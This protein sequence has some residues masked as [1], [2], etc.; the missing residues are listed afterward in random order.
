MIICEVPN[1]PVS[2]ISVMLCIRRFSQALES[3][4]CPKAVRQKEEHT[5]R[6]RARTVSDTQSG[7]KGDVTNFCHID[8]F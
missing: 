3:S 7:F 6:K 5:K 2:L 8:L 1:L 4:F